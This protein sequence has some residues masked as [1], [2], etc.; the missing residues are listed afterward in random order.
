MTVAQEAS[1]AALAPAVSETAER[2][3]QEHS[4]WIY[5]YCLRFL[6]S[7]EEAEDALQATYLNA[8]RSLGAGVRPT[9]GSAWL[10]RIAQ[11][12]CLTRLRASGRRHRLEHVQ[13]V[14]ILEETIPA[15]DRPAEELIGLTGA[16]AS[17][18]DRQRHAIL[19]R[20]WQGLSHREVARR[21][22]LTEG[23]AET[24][25]F[26]A[27][28]SLAAALENP[29]ARGRRGALR[30]LDLGGLVTAVKSF[31]A[32]SAAVKTVAAVTVVAA[33]TATVAATDPGGIWRAKPD[34]VEAKATKPFLRAT[35]AP[36][37]AS[38]GSVWAPADAALRPQNPEA[39]RSHRGRDG[40][41]SGREVGQ[42]TAAA[43]KAKDKGAGNGL[44][45]GHDK[46]AS[47]SAKA[48]NA[49]GQPAS[50]GRPSTRPAGPPA[51]AQ[52]NGL[53]KSSSRSRSG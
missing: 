43:A 32:G 23:A 27:R 21:L 12:V 17:L 20:E 18:P 26:R 4:G 9:V 52:A 44:A 46:K 8:C 39:E 42:A 38:S 37:A 53:A 33:T 48:S 31:F 22:G 3:F 10:L 7:P 51:H 50:A 24:L 28:R 2:L 15:P 40:S 1:G 49:Q 30:A 5:G 45:L 25:I 41:A 35:S 11:N 36:P 29:G 6:R 47:A 19:L 34:P 13:D 16:L 14:T